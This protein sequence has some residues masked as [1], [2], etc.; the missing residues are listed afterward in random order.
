MKE[1]S[2]KALLN[3]GLLSLVIIVLGYLLFIPT[4]DW[5]TIVELVK[6]YWVMLVIDYIACFIVLHMFIWEI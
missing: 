4:H 6:E 2:F 1:W 3:T 5:E